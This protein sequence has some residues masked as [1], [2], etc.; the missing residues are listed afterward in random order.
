MEILKQLD[1]AL[2]IAGAS[3]FL[4]IAGAEVFQVK[5]QIQGIGAILPLT[6]SQ[7][8]MGKLHCCV[9]SNDAHASS[10]WDE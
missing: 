5:R 2:E 6:H 4:R 1:T 9:A 10:S 7:T 8:L 3:V